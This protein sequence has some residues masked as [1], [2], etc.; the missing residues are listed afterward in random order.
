MQRTVTLT[1][2]LAAA[3]LSAAPA[4]AQQW[5]QAS[6]SEA[7]GELKS[8]TV[9]DLSFFVA[10]RA[11]TAASDVL[12]IYNAQTDTWT[13]RH[14]SIPRRG[15]G[16][17]AVGNYVLFAG[18][19]FFNQAPTAVIDVWDVQAG[20]WAPSTSLSQGRAELGATTVGD[21]VLFAGGILPGQVMSDRVD[22]YDSTLGPPSFRGA[23]TQGPALSVPRSF[24]AAETV[25]SKAL[26]AGGGSPSTSY[27]TVDIYDDV[28]GL[29]SAAT[30]SQAR[31][32]GNNSS[33]SVGSLAIFA[34]GFLDSN[35]PMSNV[36]D[37]YDGLTDTWD[38]AQLSVGRSGA[39]IAA[40]GN[41]VFI[42][43][44]LQGGPNPVSSAVVDRYNVATGRWDTIAD[45]SVA[46]S[47]LG[48]A[49]GGNKALFAGGLL[50]Q[51]SSTLLVD[52]YEPVGINYCGAAANSSGAAASI[53]A[54]G[55]A[56]LAAN[57]LVLTAYDV[58]NTPFLFF[59]GGAQTQQPFGDGYLCAAGGIVRIGAPAVA[60]GGVAKTTV[61]L[62]SAGFTTPGTRNV[63]C[64]FRDVAAGGAGFNTSDAAAITFVP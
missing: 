54:T 37:I 16:V 4:Q 32:I 30:L 46:R 52:I 26:F 12:D 47:F 18:G 33:I 41:H 14:L 57:D 51:F 20:T 25:G 43:G 36:V 24:I 19:G 10:G 3:A 53:D 11:D 61:N 27:D 7:R 64:W 38:V 59:H 13:V 9:G 31:G 58:P 15:V 17:A 62:P 63:Q 42:A 60:A 55:S 48:G 35:A 23:W 8:I 29:W 5:S 21:K 6:L 56:S 44:G 34:G 40:L 28:S 49:N 45:L 1:I 2:L 39:G 50:G 22:I